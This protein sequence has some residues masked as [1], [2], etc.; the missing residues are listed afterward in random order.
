MP[1]KEIVLAIFRRE[2]ATSC[3]S[4]SAHRVPISRHLCVIGMAGLAI[5]PLTKSYDLQ[6]RKTPVVS[7]NLR[8][9]AYQ[10]RCRGVDLSHSVNVRSENYTPNL[11]SLPLW[12]PALPPVHDGRH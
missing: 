1:N 9:L 2:P 11:H 12:Y 4:R 10:Y 5:H 7:P 8:K 6:V 3:A